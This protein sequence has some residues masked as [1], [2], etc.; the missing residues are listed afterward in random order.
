MIRNDKKKD[1]KILRNFNCKIFKCQKMMPS[2]LVYHLK[3]F[4]RLNLDFF[5]QTKLI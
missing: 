4:L 3:Q 1:K 2:S 5:F